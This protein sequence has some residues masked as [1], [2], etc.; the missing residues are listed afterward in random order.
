MRYLAAA[1]TILK[2]PIA[3]STISWTDDGAIGSFQSLYD[4]EIIN[5]ATRVT[6]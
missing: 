6:R 4:T 5:P 3:G 1:A 2:R